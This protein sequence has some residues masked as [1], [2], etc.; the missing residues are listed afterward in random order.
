MDVEYFT[1][2]TKKGQVSIKPFISIGKS[3]IRFNTTSLDI[4]ENFGN[5]VL[6]GYDR[7]RNTL[8]IKPS[9]KTDGSAHVLSYKKQKV[10][11][12]QTVLRHFGISGINRRY[13]DFKKENGIITIDLSQEENERFN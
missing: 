3:Y 11:S 6:I 9:L 10:I 7:K 12:C 1:K 8:Y 2:D 4:I 5:Y 13:Y